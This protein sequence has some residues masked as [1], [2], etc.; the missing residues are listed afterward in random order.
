[1]FENAQATGEGHRKMMVT[2]VPGKG[3]G[4][5]GKGREGDR[6]FYAPSFVFCHICG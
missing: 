5:W 2:L 1:M 3:T 4:G 6:F